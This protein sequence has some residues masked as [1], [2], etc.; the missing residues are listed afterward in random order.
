MLYAAGIFSEDKA[1]TRV[2]LQSRGRRKRAVFVRVIL[3]AT[4]VCGR[5]LTVSTVDFISYFSF[6]SAGC[7]NG[8]LFS[9][10]TLRVSVLGVGIRGMHCR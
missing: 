2:R 10:S 4:I 3:V 8:F 5:Q 1:P 9:Y 6:E 7:V